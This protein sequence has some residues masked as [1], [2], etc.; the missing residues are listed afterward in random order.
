MQNSIL[1]YLEDSSKKYKD[2]IA[3]RDES[4]EVTYENLKEFS[5]RIGSS[6]S[7][8]ILNEPVAVIMKKSAACVV[9][10]FG[11]A[12]SGNYYVPMDCEMPLERIQKILEVLKPKIICTDNSNYEKIKSLSFDG[13]ILLYE[14]AILS[15]IDE[16]RL[17]SFENIDCNP[18][19]IMFTSGSTGTPKGVV[20]S[21]RSVI[22]YTEWAC[23]TF[24]IRESDVIGNQ[25][26][27]FFDNSI[28]D[29]YCGI[30]CGCTIDIIPKLLF[31]FPL[32]LIE[33]MNK[34][35]IS[36]ILWVPSVLCIVADL[37]T[38]ERVIPM[39]LNK[40]LFCGEAMPN[41]QLNIWRNAKPGTLFAN[42]YGPTEI[43]DVCT[44]YIVNRKFEDYEPLPIGRPCKNTE[45][46]VLNEKEERV[47]GGEIGELC[48]K[49]TSL[50]L[51]YYNNLEETKKAFI[52]NPLNNNYPELIY[53]TGD[54]VKYNELGELIFVCRKDYQ[55]KH[56]GYRIE[57]GD[58][59]I[60]ALLI[61]EINT[62]VCLYDNEK[63][64]IVMVYSGKELQKNY[65]KE[66][67]LKRIAAYMIPNRI[68]YTEKFEYNKN[69]KISRKKMHEIYVA[70]R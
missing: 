38:F 47:K 40:V 23:E 31:T 3:I 17:K 56:M 46:L 66:E 55:I 68:I 4:E 34:R 41:K 30:R 29:I 9:T 32:K 7:Y 67:L 19:Y 24:N 5:M 35:K 2:K 8:E 15:D 21:H 12:Y 27:F 60:N 70:N 57:L 51:G 49:G 45:V 39:Y 54:L 13:K 33:Y 6:I 43:T 64:K 25:A 62:C 26:P 63:K 18:L 58:I 65:I 59:E 14:K 48:V 53:K 61:K 69:F 37:K 16:R 20:V 28:F 42:L 10:F 50:A 1:Q 22:D 44:Y 11:I 52:Q 36:I